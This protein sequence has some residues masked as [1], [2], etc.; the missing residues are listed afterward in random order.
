MSTRI[1]LSIFSGSS[2]REMRSL[3]FDRSRVENLSKIPMV[4]VCLAIRTELTQMRRERYRDALVRGEKLLVVEMRQLERLGHDD[5]L[6]LDTIGSVDEVC[7]VDLEQP[8]VQRGRRVGLGREGHD[9]H[10]EKDDRRR[11]M[12]DDAEVELTGGF[13]HPKP[14]LDFA[15]AHPIGRKPIE[16]AFCVFFGHQRESFA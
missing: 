7:R 6:V 2:A 12:D 8:T 13:D 15:E 5:G 10:A 3:M 9:L 14:R 11:K 1:W 16:P 4:L